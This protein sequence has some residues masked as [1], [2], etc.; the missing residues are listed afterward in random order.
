V[1]S[2]VDGVVTRIEERGALKVI[3]VKA[4]GKKKEIE[5]SLPRS[6]LLFTESGK[7]VKR[8]AQL[9]EGN[10]DL[11]ELLEYKGISDVERYIASEV[12]QIYLSEGAYIN[13][14]HIEVIVRQ[15]FSRVRV[16]DAGDAPDFVAGEIIEKP[17]FLEVN[18]ELKKAGRAPAKAEQVLMGITQISLTTESF[19]SAASFQDTARVLVRGAIEGRIDRLRGL[20]ENVI[21]GRLIPVGKESGVEQVAATERE[22]ALPVVAAEASA[23][24]GGKGESEAPA[25]AEE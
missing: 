7:E 9:S 1:L 17:R 24:G 25:P 12:Q 18:R 4:E 22:D 2:P 10:L 21:I 6:A 23:E 19:L 15:M 3:I 20:K 16:K 5:L 11:R 13:N 14:K 8:G